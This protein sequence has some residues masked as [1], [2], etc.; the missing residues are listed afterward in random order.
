M[1]AI[2]LGVPLA[3]SLISTSAP[4]LAST[5]LSPVL[6]SVI[7]GLDLAAVLDNPRTMRALIDLLHQRGV[8]VIKGQAL[9]DAEYVRFGRQWGRPLEFFIKEH[10]GQEHPEMIRINNDPA[11]PLAMRDGAVHWHSDG[12]YEAEPAAITML[13][14][15]EAPR[16][17]GE[18]LFAST[19]AAFDALPVSRQMALEGLV[20]IHEL[21]AA[22]WIEGETPP[23][24]N[25]PKRDMPRQRHPLIMRHPVT[26]RRAL[27]TSGTACGV[28]GMD[29][30]AA[31]TLIR[32]LR[33]HVVQTQFRISYKVLPGDIVLWDNYSTV[34]SATPIVY[35]DAEGER[36]LLYRISTKGVPALFR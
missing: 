33:T 27:F 23:D 35:S 8:L 21:G 16:D 19:A 20:A 5:P 34:H 10:R 9:S 7:A 31:T 12:S 15:K 29:Q 14:G 24:P 4:T 28:D 3:V 25:R 36:R 32:H 22:P 26:G 17:G 11:T 18:T 13:Y 6:G 30:D 2:R 1:E